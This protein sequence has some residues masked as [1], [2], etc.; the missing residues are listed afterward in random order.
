[1]FFLRKVSFIFQFALC[2]WHASNQLRCFI[3][4]IGAKV[5]ILPSILSFTKDTFIT[6]ATGSGL[7]LFAHFRNLS[8]FYSASSAKSLAR[9]AS[10]KVGSLGVCVLRQRFWLRHGPN[11][12]YGRYSLHALLQ[13]RHHAHQAG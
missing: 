2:D 3:A 11:Y 5:S 7:T 4:K 8:L 13:I 12:G 9:V 6:A 1:M 10:S